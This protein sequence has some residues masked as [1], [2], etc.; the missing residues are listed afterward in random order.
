MKSVILF[1]LATACLL[2]CIL[3][4]RQLKFSEDIIGALRAREEKE[5]LCQALFE[6]SRKYYATH[7]SI[8]SGPGPFASTIIN[9]HLEKDRILFSFVNLDPQAPW[10]ELWIMPL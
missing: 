6:Y 5:L 4:M 2:Q 10:T 8:Y 1:L 3:I 7:K 9:A